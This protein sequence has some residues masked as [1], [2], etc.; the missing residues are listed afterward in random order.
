MQADVEYASALIRDVKESYLDVKVMN[1]GAM[2]AATSMGGLADS[3]NLV[4]D[5]RLSGNLLSVELAGGNP[6]G[7]QPF[8][9]IKHSDNYYY[10]NFDLQEKGS[11]WTYIFDSQTI[12]L[13]LVE[14]IGIAMNG[15]NGRPYIKVINI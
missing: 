7:A 10:D 15:V 8:L 1:A 4:L 3:G 14:S 5:V 9:A 13:N 12:E 11:K 6:F 2:E